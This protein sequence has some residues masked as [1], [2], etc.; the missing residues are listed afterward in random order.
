LGYHHARISPELLETKLV[1]VMDI[2][3]ERAASVGETLQ[4]PYYSDLDEFLT[5]ARPDALSIVVPTVSTL[6][7]GKKNYGK[8]YPR[9]HRKAGHQDSE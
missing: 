3:E 5:K 1:G 8:K 7:S 6:R 9:A 4:V 2:D